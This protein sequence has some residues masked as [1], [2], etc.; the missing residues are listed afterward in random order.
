MLLFFVAFT[1]GEA[2]LDVIPL[3]LCTRRKI[4]LPLAQFH[5]F[6]RVCSALMGL[7]VVSFRCVY[8]GGSEKRKKAAEP[9]AAPVAAEVQVP[10]EQP[11]EDECSEPEEFDLDEKQQAMQPSAFISLHTSAGKGVEK[12]CLQ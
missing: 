8:I 10:G 2:T 7:T 12:R 1:L 5:G 11:H 6:R 4:S 9:S 3:C